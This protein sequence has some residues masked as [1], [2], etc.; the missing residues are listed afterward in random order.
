MKQIT[1]LDLSTRRIV[2]RRS[3]TEYNEIR[4]HELNLFASLGTNFQENHNQ[5]YITALKDSLKVK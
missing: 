5:I 3:M 1:L 2:A 4:Y